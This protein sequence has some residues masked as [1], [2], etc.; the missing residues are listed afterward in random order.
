M[1]IT[2]QVFHRS[3]KRV[4]NLLT[5]CGQLQRFSTKIVDENVEKHRKNIAVRGI[6]DKIA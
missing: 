6:V 3:G 5:T 1:G 4:D 2:F